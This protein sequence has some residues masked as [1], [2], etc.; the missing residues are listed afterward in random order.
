[1]VLN[2][3]GSRAID[4]IELHRSDGNRLIVQLRPPMFVDQS[5]LPHRFFQE[6]S[7][8][9]YRTFHQESL[10]TVQI[11][12]PRRRAAD[13]DIGTLGAKGIIVG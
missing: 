3:P 13:L 8:N 12:S 2:E 10:F 5:R 4:F 7:I 9:G 11:G 1:M 6:K